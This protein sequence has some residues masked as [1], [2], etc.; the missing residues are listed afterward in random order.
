MIC[1]ISISLI[2]HYKVILPDT[3]S[4]IIRVIPT[5]KQVFSE[6]THYDITHRIIF[7]NREKLDWHVLILLETLSSEY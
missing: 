7:F 6:E 3:L 1:V 4:L 5:R 2:N